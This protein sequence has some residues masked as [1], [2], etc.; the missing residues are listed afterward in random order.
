MEDYL[1]GLIKNSRF[2][3]HH[4]TSLDKLHDILKTPKRAVD[5]LMSLQRN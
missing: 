5:V 2:I 1:S 3:E 4:E